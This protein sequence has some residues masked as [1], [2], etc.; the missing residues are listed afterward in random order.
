M[1]VQVTFI[2]RS[3]RAYAR[4]S[5]VRRDHREREHVQARERS[6]AWTSRT[7]AG[8]SW[9]SPERLTDV[10]IRTFTRRLR[11]FAEPIFYLLTYKRSYWSLPL[12]IQVLRGLMHRYFTSFQ[13][14][15]LCCLTYCLVLKYSSVAGHR[16]Q[17][18]LCPSPWLRKC[19]SK[20][21]V[22]VI[23]RC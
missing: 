23:C 22:A 5:G 9:T 8:R 2:E 14:F 19:I 10:P 18:T 6:R 21:A 20:T 12:R 16:M 1:N 17:S 7:F 13:H 11:T 4:T 3:P 15:C